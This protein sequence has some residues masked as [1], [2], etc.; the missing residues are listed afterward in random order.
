MPAFPAYGA[1]LATGLA[2]EHGVLDRR[3]PHP[4]PDAALAAAG[5]QLTG[6]EGGFG[7]VSCHDV[8]TQAALAGPDTATINFAFVADR[9]RPAYYWR[10]IRDPQR[11]R[12]GTMMPSFIAEDG[13][14]PIQQVLEGNARR[15]FEAIWHYLRS[16]EGTAPVET[17]PNR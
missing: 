16:L 13:S 15:Q 14:T 12:P 17:P 7:C 10:Y 5:R 6:I 8:G 1:W 11:L 9:L 3:E 2:H 4:A